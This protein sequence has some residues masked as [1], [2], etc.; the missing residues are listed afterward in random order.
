MLFG[1]WGKGGKAYGYT[2]VLVLEV[3]IV[4]ENE[5]QTMR[6]QPSL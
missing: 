3:R 1:N 4:G 5:V 6:I 2:N